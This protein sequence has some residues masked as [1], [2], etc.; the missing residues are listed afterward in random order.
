MSKVIRRGPDRGTVQKRGL[1]SSR[2]SGLGGTLLGL[3][4]GLALGLALAAGVAFYL[5]RAPNPYQTL[6]PGREAAR[7]TKET[8]KPGRVDATATEKPRFDFY[9][10]LPG[11][12]E[13]KVQPKAAD[14]RS[15]D[16]ATVERAV[17]PDKAIAKAED[18]P[19]VPPAEKEPKA[20]ERYWLQ[21][22]SFTNEAD[23]EN[24]KAQLAFEGGWE[25]TI[26]PSNVPDKGQR[27][28]VRLGPFDNTDELT[29][30]KTALGKRGFD[31]A[32]IKY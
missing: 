6:S 10:I 3:F 8:V 9:K 14:S 7:D 19:A 26:Q 18:R 15:S 27:Y 25:A 2:K 16:K 30:I 28:R 22:G 32:V 29:R 20:A 5:S 21:V 13:P 17:T 12:E 24:L 11:T 23:A 31:G 1:G 4:I